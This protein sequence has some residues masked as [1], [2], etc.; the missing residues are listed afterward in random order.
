MIN[1]KDARL[2]VAE[3]SKPTVF[4]REKDQANTSK[5]TEKTTKLNQVTIREVEQARTGLYFE[6]N[7]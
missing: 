1:P 2:K 4:K 6:H 7:L 3:S 5:S